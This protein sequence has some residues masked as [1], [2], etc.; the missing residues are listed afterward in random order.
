MPRLEKEK[1]MAECLRRERGSGTTGEEETGGPV[2]GSGTG[3][4]GGQQ[5]GT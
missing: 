1:K 2:A 5:R 4:G 3:V